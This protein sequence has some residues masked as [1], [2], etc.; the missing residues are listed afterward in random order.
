HAEFHGDGRQFILHKAPVSDAPTGNYFFKSQPL[1]NGHQ[2][3]YASPLAQYI[4]E[5]A[6]IAD[7]PSRELTFSLSDSDRV[8]SGAKSLVGLSGEL[9]VNLVTFSMTAGQQDIS[10][11]YILSGGY[12]DDGEWI[13]EEQV[14]DLL[15][16]T[17]THVGKEVYVDQ[18]RFLSKL[19]VRKAEIEREVQGRN[20]Q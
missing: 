16:L 13:D 20:A 14:A 15:E 19:E 7:T 9:T 8:T 3:R 1:E 4:I 2:Y 6:R 18:R 17:C 10:E 12:I 11:S 5:T